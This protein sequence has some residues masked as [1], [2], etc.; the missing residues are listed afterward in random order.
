MNR[1]RML[2]LVRHL[3]TFGGGY[4]VAKGWLD[5]GQMAEVIG[6][7]ITIVGAV[8]SASAPEKSS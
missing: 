3:L 4:L 2:G 1:Q 7:V 8:W 6:G 5:E